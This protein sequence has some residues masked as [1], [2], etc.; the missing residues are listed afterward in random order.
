[1]NSNGVL[2]FGGTGFIEYTPREFPFPSPPLIAPFWHDFNPNVGGSIFYRQTN[3]SAQL[4]LVHT[5]LSDLDVEGLDLDLANFHPTQLFIATWYQVPPF[6]LSHEVHSY[7]S[8]MHIIMQVLCPY[9]YS[10][11]TPSK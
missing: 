5:M 3:D 8:N 1:M 2:S 6:G 9:M 10:Y 7:T 11:R 4:Q